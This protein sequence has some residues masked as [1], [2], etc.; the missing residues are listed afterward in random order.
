V[1]PTFAGSVVTEAAFG[2]PSYAA[3]RLPNVIVAARGV[4]TSLSDSSVVPAK[5]SVAM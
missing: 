4:T 5:L 3:D 1:V 2:W